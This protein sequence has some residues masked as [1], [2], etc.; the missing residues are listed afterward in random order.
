VNH[1]DAASSSR[2]FYCG[3]PRPEAR[4]RLFCFPPAGGATTAYFSW[5]KYLP[6]AVEL[7]ACQMPGRE[8]RSGETPLTDLE[9]L[10]DQLVTAS[11]PLLDP[12]FAFFGHSLGGLIAFEVV[13]ALRRHQRPLPQQ[14]IV[15]GARAP[16]LPPEAPPIHELSKTQF[17]AEMQRRW[18]PLPEAVRHDP[19]LLDFFLPILRADLTMLETYR[20]RDE[21]PLDCP[22]T[23]YGGENDAGASRADLRA[24]RAQ[25]RD[26]LALVLFDG[27]HFFPQSHTGAVLQDLAGR[28]DLVPAAS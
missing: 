25:T 4:I 21:P 13:R 28:L 3:Q 12:P 23:A 5:P 6:T 14:L 7:Y 27:G 11:E 24:W 16:Q 10:V 22:I 26:M 18:G 1:T 2:W 17:F 15:A 8:R 9:L 20:Y 19:Q